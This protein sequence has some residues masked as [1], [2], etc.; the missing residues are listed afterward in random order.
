MRARLTEDFRAAPTGVVMPRTYKAGEIVDGEVA[1]W[2]LEAKKAV[3]VK[4][5]APPAREKVGAK[6]VPAPAPG[7]DDP[8][9]R[10]G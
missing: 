6:S 5:T 2:A 3:E 8:P 10:K 7:N 4:D 9:A 1:A